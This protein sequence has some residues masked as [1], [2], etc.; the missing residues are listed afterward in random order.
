VIKYNFIGLDTFQ[1]AMGI[2]AKKFDTSVLTSKIAK[3][4]KSST[5]RK[6]SDGK[7][8]NGEKPLSSLTSSTR[9]GGNA[10]PLQDTNTFLKSIEEVSTSTE[11][12]VGSNLPY[13]KMITEG[14]TIKPKK[15]KALWIPAS[16][17]VATKIK[18]GMTIGQV[19]EEYKSN[20]WNV[21]IPPK[22]KNK[23]EG[24]MLA[25]RK[26]TKNKGKRNE[27]DT[28]ETKMLFIIR[29]SVKIP[30]RNPFYVD[31]DDEE[32]IND[33]AID[34]LKGLTK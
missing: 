31:K 1:K 17:D 28:H 9:R 15:A 25:E 21:F 30:K 4:L 18:Q 33:L 11:V 20:G 2:M 5:M 29:K 14:G 8:E 32:V 16:N 10:K 34:F 22:Y 26:E 12:A 7:F 19:I 3:Y 24:V 13:S 27:K 23:G 6:I